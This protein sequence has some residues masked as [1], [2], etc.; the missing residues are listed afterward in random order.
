MAGP[1]AWFPDYPTASSFIQ[2]NFRCEE[3]VNLSRF[4]DATLDQRMSEARALQATDPV[5]AAEIW[6][7]LD[8]I[9]TDAAPWVP[10][11]T[12]NDTF[13]VSERVG[14][15]QLHQQWGILPDQL[16]VE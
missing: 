12:P 2:V 6:A 14:N 8:R 5:A 10:L 9:I 3:L 13:F 15:V 4:C 11:V 7:D 1:L 16:W